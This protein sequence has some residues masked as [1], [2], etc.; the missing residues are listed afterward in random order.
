MN[1][2]K[3]LVSCLV[4]MSFL[5][6]SAQEK[7]AK[8]EYVFNPHWYVQ[9]QLGGQY[10]LG[11]LSF[12]DLLSPNGQIGVGY[13]FN[14]VVGARFAVNAWQSKAGWEMGDASYDWKWNYIAPN[15]DL[16]FNLS[17]LFCGYNP[18]RIFN[19]SAFAGVGL[20]VAWGNDDAEAAKVAIDNYYNVGGA[21]QNLAYLWDG[22]KV[23]VQGQIGV[24]A[25][26][27]VT[28]KI[29]LGL[30]LSANTLGDRYNSKRAGNNDWYFN[31]LAGVKIALGKTHTTREV[32][33]CC[34]EPRVV[35]KIIERVVEKPVPVAPA[36]QEVAKVEPLRRDI[37]FTISSTKIVNEEMSK[38]AEIAE[39]QTKYP[40]AKVVITGY[41]DKGT[42]NAKINSGLAAKRSKAVVDALV[43]NYGISSSRISSDSKGDT[44]QPFAEHVKNRV[45]ICIAQ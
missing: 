27:R 37:F 24:M 6:V 17:N 32:K 30:E 11:E 28:E 33:P 3:A 16:T 23:R 5:A 20:N 8:T 7:K 44:V 22:T 15:V 12:G 38:V 39:Y 43:N 13:N 4:A 40:A 1:I 34:P 19:F 36:V 31:A 26:F 18:N 21:N 25:D 14:P 42:G 29:S 35:E 45:S 10:T 2:K 41:A 9:A